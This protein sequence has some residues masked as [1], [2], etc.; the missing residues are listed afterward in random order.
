MKKTTQNNEREKTHVRTTPTYTHL[1]LMVRVL[2]QHPLEGE[3]LQG[4][5]AQL[6]A[7]VDPSHDHPANTTRPAKQKSCDGSKGAPANSRRQGTNDTVPFFLHTA[8]ILCGS[9]A[10]AMGAAFGKDQSDQSERGHSGRN[11]T[12]SGGKA[13]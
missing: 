1:L 4:D 9:I 8:V 10:T 6:L 13:A 7:D 3:Q 2:R 5:P 11:W 12:E